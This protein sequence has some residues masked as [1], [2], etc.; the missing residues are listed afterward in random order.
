MDDNGG[1]GQLEISPWGTTTKAIDKR[2]RGRV[3]AQERYLERQR[4]KKEAQVNKIAGRVARF[5]YSEMAAVTRS[6]PTV[7]EAQR[8]RILSEIMNRCAAILIH[9]MSAGDDGKD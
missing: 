8:Q 1:N 7:S 9:P 4:K 3:A 6:G 2:A 5:L